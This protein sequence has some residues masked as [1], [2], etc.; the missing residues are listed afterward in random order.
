MSS[1]QESVVTNLSRYRCM[2]NATFYPIIGLEIHVELKTKSKM[3]SQSSANYFGSLP[4][5]HIDPV[6]LGLPGAL[7]VPNK[8]AIEW[9]IMIAKALGCKIN[10]YTRFD[11]K[12]YFYPDLP[13]GYQI[14]QFT[15]P[16]GYN[17]SVLVIFDDESEKTYRIRRVHLEEDTGKLIHEGSNTYVD[18]NRAGVPLVEIVTEADFHSSEEVKRF[19]EELQTIVRYHDVADADLEKGDMRLEPN[20]SVKMI[21]D[22]E[23]HNGTFPPYKVEVKNINSFRFAKMAVDYEINRQTELLKKGETPI[24]E[25][26]GYNEKKAMT[27]SQRTK[28]NAE[29]YR[30]FPEP[31]IPP[32]TFTDEYITELTKTMPELPVAKLR[33]LQNQYNMSFNNAFIISRDIP[34]AETF[35]SVVGE[36][37]KKVQGKKIAAKIANMIVNKKVDTTLE[38]KKLIEIIV[39]ALQPKHVDHAALQSAIVTTMQENPTVVQD[40]KAGKEKAIMFLVGQVMRYMK[41]QADAQ[42][43]RKK[44]EERMKT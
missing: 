35:E 38:Q 20:I 40:Y 31:D 16:M 32:F 43:I 41:G 29:D 18:Y 5:T 15:Y 17:G 7:P 2:S 36:V 25:T 4:N 27:V 1:F 8:Q 10:K 19:L 24:Q 3:F 11:R 44:L 37:S 21:R 42:D 14:T 22:E 9:T 30:Y 34:L 39:Q 26:R 28:E 13:K 6:V 33:R 23:E 12:H